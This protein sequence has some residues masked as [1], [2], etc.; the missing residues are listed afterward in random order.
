MAHS[1]LNS[2]ALEQGNCIF[3]WEDHSL[4]REPQMPNRIRTTTLGKI[5]K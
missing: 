1:S 3:F 2:S 5:A 4:P